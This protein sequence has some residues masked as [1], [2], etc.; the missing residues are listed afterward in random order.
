[1][2][3]R[4]DASD[5][6]AV[7]FAKYEQRNP[8]LSAHLGLRRD[9]G[10]T[11]PMVGSPKEVTSFKPEV[12]VFEGAI[13]DFPQPHVEENNVNYLAGIKEIGV[14][15]AY[16]DGRDMPRLA[17][18]SVA[19]E[20]PLYDAW[21]PAT[22]TSI[23]IDS[24]SNNEPHVYAREIIHSFATRAFR[25]GITAAEEQLLYD[26]WKR[27]FSVDH[28]FQM[29][30]K[31]A[32][33]VALTSPQFLYIA[34]SSSGPEAET[35]E[36]YELASKL[37]YFLWN[38][39]PDD[40]LLRLASNGTIHSSLNEEIGRLVGDVRFDDFVSEFTTQ[41]LNIDAFATVET[42]SKLFPT[43]TRDTKIEL[44][45]EPIEFMSYLFK[46]DLPLRNII[47]SDF[48]LANEVV[49]SYYGL[50]EQSESG[51][52]F[53]ANETQHLTSRR[54]PLSGQFACGAL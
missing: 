8:K 39:A 50:A 29:S 26:V 49:A 30:I 46:Q 7:A 45:R 6:A 44:R 51:F 16:T 33:L 18:H 20:G 19:F 14:R 25:R 48:I 21:P 54:G 42:N 27:S 35:I 5:P 34:E 10:S 3:T 4:L 1:M 2:L 31:D 12:F 22:H 9:C 52:E 15:H 36:S 53:F 24:S 43:L 11:L 38:T 28:D 41:W 47:D 23:F 40:R 32:L 13:R 17:I 37:S